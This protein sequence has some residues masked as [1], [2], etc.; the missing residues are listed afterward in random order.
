MS[1]DRMKN[2]N[3]S[4][5]NG[6][7]TRWAENIIFFSILINAIDEAWIGMEKMSCFF[8]HRANENVKIIWSATFDGID[9]THTDTILSEPRHK[10]L[11]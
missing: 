10:T 6:N 5:T 8:F 7:F 2:W 1:S 11:E 9:D 3:E 4:T